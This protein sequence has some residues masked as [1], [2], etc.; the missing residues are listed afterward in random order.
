MVFNGVS[1]KDDMAS[2]PLTHV[3]MTMLHLPDEDEFIGGAQTVDV[4]IW[5]NLSNQKI[6]P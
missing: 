6:L 5:Q 4:P 3:R 2:R 1:S